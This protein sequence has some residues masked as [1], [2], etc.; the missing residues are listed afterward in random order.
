MTATAPA[1][2]VDGI[3]KSFKGLAVLRGVSFDVA[4]GSVFALLG[5]NGAGK[6]TLVRIL[7]TL[8]RA[9]A[10]SAQVA[11]LDEKFTGREEPRTRQ[12][13][14]RGRRR[15]RRLP[16][17]GHPAHHRRVRCGVYGVPPVPPSSH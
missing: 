4:P 2:R 6:T 13:D 16:A 11:G 10:G 9:D 14:R 17:A 8:S 1:I 15:V 12:R 3:E 7:A 5:A